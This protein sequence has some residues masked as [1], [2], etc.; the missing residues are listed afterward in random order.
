MR[1]GALSERELWMRLQDWWIEWVT[2]PIYRRALAH[3]LRSGRL[4][5]RNGDPYPL[6]RLDSLTQVTAQGR[7]WP[8]VDP[9][10]DMQS[11]RESVALGV[12]SISDIIRESGRDPEEVWAELGDDYRQMDAAGVPRPLLSP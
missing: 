6:E 9:L 1:Q 5:R 10:K 7:R 4:L 11:N 12:R 3:A 2:K 8:W